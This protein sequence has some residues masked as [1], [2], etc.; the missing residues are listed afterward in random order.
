MNTPGR[1]AIC[2]SQPPRLHTLFLTVLARLLNFLY[3]RGHE[4]G[5]QLL[6]GVDD[7]AAEG[8][9]AVRQADVDTRQRN[10]RGFFPP[11]GIF[12]KQETEMQGKH[13]DCHNSTREMC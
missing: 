3:V 6:C 13:E 8:F 12:L 10:V 2:A 5:A 4:H 11:L 7:H 1:R 9:E